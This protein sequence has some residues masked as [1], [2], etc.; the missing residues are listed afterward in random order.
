M[1]IFLFTTWCFYEMDRNFAKKM[2]N[3]NGTFC[4]NL[5]I[6]DL[7]IVQIQDLCQPGWIQ[8]MDFSKY[9]GSSLFFLGGGDSLAFIDHTWTIQEN[10]KN[11]LKMLKFIKAWAGMKTA[12]NRNQPGCGFYTGYKNCNPP[13]LTTAT[14]LSNYCNLVVVFIPS[15]KTATLLI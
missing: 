15:I 11:L 14:P 3:G 6:F 13:Y 9:R 10:A 5:L 12:T 2:K 8:T 1:C 4:Q 7:D